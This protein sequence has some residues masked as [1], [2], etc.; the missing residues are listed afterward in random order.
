MCGPGRHKWTSAGAF[1]AFL[2]LPVL[3]RAPYS[4]K[5]RRIARQEG[6]VG[7]QMGAN[8]TCSLPFKQNAFQRIIPLIPA[9][10]L[11]H[12]DRVR[13]DPRLQI[14]GGS[15]EHG[16]KYKRVQRWMIHTPSFFYENTYE[17]SLTPSSSYCDGTHPWP[18]DSDEWLSPQST[19]HSI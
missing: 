14:Q 9:V 3:L 1:I 11:L 8:E 6:D 13:P 18:L 15:L 17:D 16:T 12:K 10:E 7:H 4:S 2:I 5:R 19:I